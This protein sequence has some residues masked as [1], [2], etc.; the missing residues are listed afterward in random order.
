MVIL[1]F[2][3]SSE[4]KDML[5]KVNKMYKFSK[6]LKECLEDKIEEEVDDDDD[7]RYEDEDERHERMS[8]RGSS[9]RGGRYRRG[10]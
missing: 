8:E 7:Y 9:Y 2:R 1:R 3:T 5:K 4:A 10:M 6:E